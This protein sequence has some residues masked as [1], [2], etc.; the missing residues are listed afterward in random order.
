MRLICPACGAQASL[1]A[2]AADAGARE[3]LAAV[4]ALPGPLV[5]YMPGYLALFRRPDTGRALT[6]SR[7]RKIVA[8]I[9]ALTAAGHVQRGGRA[10]RPCPASMWAQALERI[11]QSPPHR[12][13]LTSH[14]YLTEIAYTLAD[15]ADRAAEVARNQAERNGRRRA[16]LARE[17]RAAPAP[18]PMMTVEQMRAIREQNMERAKRSKP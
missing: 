1:E 18:E 3:T 6:W 15:E 17:R 5:K 7:A 9:A 13:P 14:G 2:W 11:V 16:E 12:L 10:A 4:C 8:E